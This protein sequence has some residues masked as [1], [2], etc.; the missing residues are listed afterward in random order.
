MN[1]RSFL[2]Y[3]AAGIAAAS[4]PLSLAAKAKVVAV[5]N[6]IPYISLLQH[7]S[8]GYPG[9]GAGML[10]NTRTGKVFKSIEF[11][12]CYT[13]HVFVEW[14]DRN[15]GG[16]LVAE[17]RW[18]S[19]IVKTAKAESKQFGYYVT[20][21]GHD[22]VE[23]FYLYGLMVDGDKVVTRCVLA[24]TGAKIKVY[25]NFLETVYW[26]DVRVPLFAHKLRISSVVEQARA[27]TFF[28]YC[29]E[30][31]RGEWTLLHT[32]RLDTSGS[33]N[34]PDHLFVKE[35]SKFAGELI[36]EQDNG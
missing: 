27:G 2:K 32:G 16:K 10:M 14:K 6:G 20:P 35:G 19:D 13:R 34:P 26:S 5:A 9:I 17:H 31:A 30:P 1:R 7:L 3:C 21:S 25:R 15:K 22:L 12:P 24:F 8:P 28:N 36:R 4:V 18:D 23:T 11:V 29:I 33:L